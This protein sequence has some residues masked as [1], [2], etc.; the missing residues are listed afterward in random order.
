MNR[1]AIIH[2]GIAVGIL[3]AAAI[4]LLVVGIPMIGMFRAHLGM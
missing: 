4:C 3:L 1:D 2:W